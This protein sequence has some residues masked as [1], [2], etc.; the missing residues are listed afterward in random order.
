MSLFYYIAANRELPMGSFGKNGTVMTLQDYVANVNPAAAEQPFMRTLLK[1][2]PQ[3]ER[4]ME[5]YETEE[6][7]AGLYVTDLIPGQDAS[8]VFRYPNV[9]QVNP[10]GGSFTLNDEMRT[11]Q[12][13]LYRNSY[14]CLTVLFDYLHSNLAIGEEAELYAC[15]AEGLERFQDEPRKELDLEIELSTFQLNHGFEWQVR[16]YI[17]VTR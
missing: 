8:R 4:F 12:P 13:D 1:K 10:E 14:K 15:W 6:D 7:A 3:G 16:Q 9:Y 17:R 11:S 2:Y 5:V